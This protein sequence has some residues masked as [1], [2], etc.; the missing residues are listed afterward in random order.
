MLERNAM[1]IKKGLCPFL[2][3]HVIP[4]KVHN[5]CDNFALTKKE[6]TSIPILDIES[7]CLPFIRYYHPLQPSY[8]FQQISPACMLGVNARC[9]LAQMMAS[10]HRIRPVQWQNWWCLLVIF[11][12]HFFFISCTGCLANK[13]NLFF[14][15][16]LR[17]FT[18]DRG[19]KCW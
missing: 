10:H 3:V 14:D 17:A 15:T 4:A 19:D 8:R 7:N 6:H 1:K 9:T 16:L 13:F 5:V 18:S 2:K 12:I 11:T